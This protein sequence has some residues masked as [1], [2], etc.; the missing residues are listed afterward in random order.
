MQGIAITA[1]ECELR[2]VFQQNVIFTV[3]PRTQFAYPIDVHDLRPV[4]ADKSLRIELRFHTPDCG[5][6]QMRLIADV[7]PHVISFRFNPVHLAGLEKENTSTRLD[8]DPLEIPAPAL[9]LTHMRAGA[10]ERAL[11]PVAVKRL[12]QVVHSVIVECPYR[13]F[14]VSRYKHNRS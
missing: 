3:P 12:E 11:E 1:A 2:S 4:N 5:A 7:E 14:V 13:V 8:N 6:N 9:R 10:V